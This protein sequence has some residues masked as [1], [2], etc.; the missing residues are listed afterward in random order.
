MCFYQMIN[1]WDTALS[2]TDKYTL[3]NM[4]EKIAGREKQSFTENIVV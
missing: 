3:I 2:N 4:R 1:S